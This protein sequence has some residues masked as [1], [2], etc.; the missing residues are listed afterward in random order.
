MVPLGLAPSQLRLERPR[1]RSLLLRCL[2]SRILT[3]Q[4]FNPFLF[5]IGRYQTKADLCFWDISQSLSRR[6]AEHE[7]IWRQQI[8]HAAYTAPNAQQSVN[9]T[10]AS[11][12]EEMVQMVDS[13]MHT[14]ERT[15]L[16]SAIRRIVKS[17][18]ETWRYARSA[19]CL[20]QAPALSFVAATG[21][22]STITDHSKVRKGRNHCVYRL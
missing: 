8:S 9:K 20:S 11:I 10:A 3:D 21:L 18:A 4:I 16:I 6:S 15:R 22:E 7:A 14:S 17:A 13:L 5:T 12:V 19:R 1:I 2:I